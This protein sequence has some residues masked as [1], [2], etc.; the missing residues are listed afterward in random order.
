[1]LLSQQALRHCGIGKYEGTTEVRNGCT[2]WSKLDD[3]KWL[4]PF[5]QAIE[6]IRSRCLRLKLH[7]ELDGEEFIWISLTVPELHGVSQKKCILKKSS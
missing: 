7:D 6:E 4:L 2:G 3:F 5:L 1:M